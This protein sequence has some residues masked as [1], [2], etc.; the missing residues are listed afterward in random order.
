MLCYLNRSA[1]H[2]YKILQL[3][4]LLYTHN[5]FLNRYLQLCIL[6]VDVMLCTVYTANTFRITLSDLRAYSTLLAM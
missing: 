2:Y 3:Q 5:P 4:L 6:R 1:S